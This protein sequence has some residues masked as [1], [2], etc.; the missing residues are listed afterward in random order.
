[1]AVQVVA[2]VLGAREREFLLFAPEIFSHHKNP[3]R[4]VGRKLVL[5]A[6]KCVVKPV[7]LDL[8]MVEHGVFAENYVTNLAFRRGCGVRPRAEQQTL[9]CARFLGGRVVSQA[10][11]VSD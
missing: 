4:R 3:H 8:C 6:L 7:K 9:T 1:M 5:D 11:V 2:R 10:Q